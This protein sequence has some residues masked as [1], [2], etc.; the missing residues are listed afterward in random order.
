MNGRSQIADG[1]A[2][3]AAERSKA[4]MLEVGHAETKALLGAERER[5]RMLG[6]LLED[7]KGDSATLR[8]DLAALSDQLLTGGVAVNGMGPR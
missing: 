8:A 1:G 6:E 7:L 3:L 5:G 2:A 4:G